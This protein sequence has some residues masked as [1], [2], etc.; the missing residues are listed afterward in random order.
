[1]SVGI[2]L[3]KQYE[4]NVNQLRSQFTQ[5][6]VSMHSVH[7]TPPTQLQDRL[8]QY[9]HTY[10]HRC[11]VTNK[12]AHHDLK[13]TLTYNNILQNILQSRAT[14]ILSIIRVLHAGQQLCEGPVIQKK[15]E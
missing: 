13:N 9:V 7:T 3:H 10:I 8:H 15:N 6:T 11:V 4:L 5:C 12:R 1:M 14:G 2:I